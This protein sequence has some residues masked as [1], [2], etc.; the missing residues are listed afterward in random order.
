M[1]AAPIELLPAHEAVPD[2]PAWHDL[3]RDAVTASEIAAV[4]GI[5]PWESPFSLYWRKVNGW[6]VD[7]SDEMRTGTRLEPV[8]ADWWA[9]EHDPH[10]NLA[11]IRAGLYA[12]PDRRWQVATPDRLVHLELA[13]PPLGVL[14]CKWTG[15]W[16]G[17]GEAGTD[18]IPV[19]YRAQVLWQCDVMAVDEWHVAVLGPGGFRAYHG[20]RDERDLAVM[21]EHGRRFMDR[22]IIGPAPDVD[23]HTAT[24]AVLKR[25]HPSIE[26]VDIDVPVE[27]AEGYRR[28]RI[29]ARRAAE[30]V[31]RYD[32]RARALL[33]GG[34]RLVC[35]GR[36]VVS[37]SVYEQS[38]DSAELAAIDGEWPTV[39]RLNPGRAKSYA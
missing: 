2:N 32:N 11:V 1:T 17:W 4:L 7:A 8:I 5:S 36:L 3:R 24:L 39:D 26:D 16:D 23:E 28:A 15:S 35:G 9:D 22:L 10:E 38:G 13:G 18:Q 14:E 19:Y 21:R 12:H 30:L 29:L 6:D 27:F 25:L 37:R 20:R 33:G 31:D 34:R